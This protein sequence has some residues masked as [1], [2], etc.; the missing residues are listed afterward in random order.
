MSRSY[1]VC[2]IVIVEGQELVPIAELDK[3][4]FSLQ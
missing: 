3:N 4:M 1:C 2:L